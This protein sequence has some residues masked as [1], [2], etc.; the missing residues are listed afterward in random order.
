M[1]GDLPEDWLERLRA[2]DHEAFNTLVR[3]HH[4]AVFRLAQRLL[5]N[6]DDAQEVAQECFLA[7]YEGIGRFQ[8]RASVKT[9][10]L[11]IAYRKAVDRLQ[12]RSQ[13][14][15]LVSGALDDSELWKIAQSVEQLTDWGRNPEQTFR[16]TEL[17]EHLGAALA[18][19]PAESRAVFELR[20]VQ[21]LSSQEAAEVLEINE[22]AVRVRLHRVR[23]YL[24]RELQSLFGGKG[25][26]P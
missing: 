19:L 20:D 10:L 9:W 2:Q 12:R 22:G 17:R 23:Q 16:S 15:H 8:Q 1:S 6:A 3:L 26:Q 24:M 21:G 18:R 25:V 14:G 13:E 4:A 5:R 11:S 7:A